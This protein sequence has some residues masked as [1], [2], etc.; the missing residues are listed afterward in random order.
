MVVT[1]LAAVI[2]NVDWVYGWVNVD[3]VYGWVNV[4]WVYGRHQ[5]ITV[6]T[7]NGDCVIGTRV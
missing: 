4:D 1:R 3:W 6:V 7:V 5:A 2:V